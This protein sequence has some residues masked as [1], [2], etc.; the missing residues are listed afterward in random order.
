[1]QS[2]TRLLRKRSGFTLIELL[3]VI[4]IIAIL[5]AILFPVFAQARAQARKTSCLSNVKQLGLGFMMYVQDY[6]ET[7]PIA[8][9]NPA[10]T[11]VDTV[12]PYIKN[13]G[14]ARNPD[15]TYNWNRAKGIYHCPDDSDGPA[16]VS[17]T[18]N[19]MLM[20]AG[21]PV[22]GGTWFAPKSL[23]AM[24]YPAETVLLADTNKPCWPDTGCSDTGTD[25]IR[26][27][28]GTSDAFFNYP[29]SSEDAARA[30]CIY[31]KHRDWTD[32]KADPLLCPDGTW[33]CKHP[34]FR[35]NRNGT[36]S[37]NANMTFGDGHA[38]SVRWGRLGPK[39]WLPTLSDDLAQKYDTPEECPAENLP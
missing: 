33:S 11:W 14:D 27:Q 39:N 30:V 3:V 31:T 12:D 18:T 5:A 32:L 29:E 21:N 35:H 26:A 2:V 25:F 16:Q 37:G 13:K 38:V 28:P 20:G 7:F 1:M 23:A 9:G 22:D 4:A 10:G 6:D 36:F 8:W 34:A 17:Y 19:A 15:G 24:N